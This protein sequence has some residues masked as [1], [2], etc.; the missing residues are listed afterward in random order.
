MGG[1]LDRLRPGYPDHWFLWSSRVP[2]QT[3]CPRCHA[4]VGAVIP[5][6][7]GIELHRCS[8]GRVVTALSPDGNYC[9]LVWAPLEREGRGGLAEERA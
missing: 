6:V 3:R 2:V 4:L 1:F 9:T 8:A 5:I 7:D